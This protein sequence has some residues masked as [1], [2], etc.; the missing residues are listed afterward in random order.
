MAQPDGFYT[1]K[2]Y[3]IN[4]DAPLTTAMEDYLEMICRLAKQQEAVRVGE[5]SRM[6]H[7]RASSVS[8]MVRQ[9]SDAGFLSAERY[10]LIRL[11][12]KGRTAG[13]Y[14][15]YRHAVIQRF[16]RVLNGSPDELEEAEK[17]EHFLSRGTV[18]NLE[19]LTRC[20]CDGSAGADPTG[21]FHP[22]KPP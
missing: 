18:E 13:G 1:L 17:I 15:L 5:L 4:E 6:L 21:A 20:L 2:G 14:L 16:L 12:E 3:Q 22:M 9:L 10:G 19:R 8:K 7:V 11:T